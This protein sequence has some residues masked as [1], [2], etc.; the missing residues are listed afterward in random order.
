MRGAVLR[1]LDLRLIKDRIMQ[2]SYGIMANPAF[3][4][5]HHPLD[6]RFMNLEG[7]ASCSGVMEWFAIKVPQSHEL[8]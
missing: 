1:G 6:R 5:A 3:V 8:K 7:R 2:K 4:D